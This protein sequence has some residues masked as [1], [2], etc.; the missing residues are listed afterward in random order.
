MQTENEKITYTFDE[1]KDVLGEIELILQSLHRMGSYYGDKFSTYGEEMN[2]GEYEKETTRFIDEWH[3]CGRLAKVRSILSEKFDET[4][5]EDN[6]SD[7]ERAMEKVRHWN[8][9]GD[10]P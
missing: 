1:L 10:K 7:L 4:L 3:I 2:R 8:K 5:G 9:P 6:M